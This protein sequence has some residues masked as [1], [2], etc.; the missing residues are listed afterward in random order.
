M[1]FKDLNSGHNG[2]PTVYETDRGTFVI[3]GQAV[4]DPETL[5]SLKN[6]LTGETAVEV[7]REVLLGAARSAG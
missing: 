6:V 3:Q 7:P 2:C 4:T 5:A 1:V